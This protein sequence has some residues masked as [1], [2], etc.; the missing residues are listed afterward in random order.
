VHRDLK[1]G[2]F[3]VNSDGSLRI[4]DFGWACREDDVVSGMSGSPGYAPPEMLQEYGPRHTTKADVYSLG[5]SLLHLLLG[6]MS[7]GPRDLPSGVSPGVLDFIEE[8]MH[9]DPKERPSADE[10]LA[11]LADPGLFAQCRRKNRF[12]VSPAKNTRSLRESVTVDHSAPATFGG[13]AS[14]A[15][16]SALWPSLF[17]DYKTTSAS[18][19]RG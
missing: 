10:A 15:D 1:P 14:S 7:D 18:N 4:C 5:A 9:E 17:E 19:L 2:N 16:L 12:F 6:R 11:G 13:A 8:L 3:L